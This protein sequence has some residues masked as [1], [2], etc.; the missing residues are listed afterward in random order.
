M[1]T[2]LWVE[3]TFSKGDF[4]FEEGSSG[5]KLYVVKSGWAF[6][7]KYL[8]RRDPLG[9]IIRKSIEFREV[10]LGEVLGEDSV[11]FN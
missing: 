6:L 8:E 10:C 2:N 9:N 7:H 4:L 5:K 11:F 3:K 1:T